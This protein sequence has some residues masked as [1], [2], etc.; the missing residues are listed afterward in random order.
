MKNKLGVLKKIERMNNL[1]TNIKYYFNTK[2]YQQ[3]EAGVE[4]LKNL[5]KD[6]EETVDVEDDYFLNRY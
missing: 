1:I 4:T 2:N 6:L 3:A 5:L